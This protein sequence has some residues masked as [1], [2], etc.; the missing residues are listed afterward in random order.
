MRSRLLWKLLAINGLVIGLVILTVWFTVDY[1]AADYFVELGRKY[2]V[3]P[4]ALHQMFVDSA[5]RV[6]VWSGLIALVMAG[7]LSYFLTR[8]TLRPLFQMAAISREYAAGRYD[9]RVADPTADEVGHLARAFNRMADGLCRTEELRKALVS[10]V[11]HELR[12]PLTNIRGY[13]EGL[14]DGVVLPDTTVFASLL[15]ETMRLTHLVESLLRLSHADAARATYQPAWVDLEELAGQ[16][17]DLFRP[18]LAA[19]GV[20]VT[21][22]LSAAASGVRADPDKVAQIFVNLIENACRY[23]PPGGTLRVVA[24]REPGALRVT[25]INSGEGIAPADLP[26]IFERFFR[27]EKSRSRQF[28]GAGIGLAIVKELVEVHGGQVSATSE[29]GETRIGF[30]LPK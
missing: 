13:L 10:D 16:V 1:L 25:V 5:H 18:R 2:D 24:E 4:V 12:S 6:L 29:P 8:R 9:H 27:G 7:T 20:I 14:A 3:A 22:D 17:L 19:N 11:A 28:G 15:E 26:R 23:T 21:A 30:T